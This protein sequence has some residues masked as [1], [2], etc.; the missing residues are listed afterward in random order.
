[1]LTDSYRFFKEP[2]QDL[3]ALVISVRQVIIAQAVADNKLCTD[4]PEEITGCGHTSCYTVE[5]MEPTSTRSEFRQD[6]GLPR[7]RLPPEHYIPSREA[8]VA[9]LGINAGEDVLTT[10]EMLCSRTGMDYVNDAGL[11]QLRCAADQRIEFR[12]RY[13]VQW[14]DLTRTNAFLRLTHS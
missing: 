14:H 3:R 1:L 13:Y 6:G 12:V 8:R 2:S 11:Y 4:V 9:K 5:V 10:D 7:A